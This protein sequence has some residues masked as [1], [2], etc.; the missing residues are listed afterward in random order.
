MTR[1]NFDWGLGAP[2][3]GH[4]PR[5]VLHPVDH[6]PHLHR[7]DLPVHRDRRRR[8]PG[9][10]RRR[11]RPSTGGRTRAPPP[12]GPPPPDRRRPHH[13]RRVLR[14]LAAPPSPNVTWTDITPPTTCS[15]VQWRVS[16]ST[17]LI[18][19]V[20]RWCAADDAIN[21]DWGLGAPMAGH[22]PRHGSPPG[23]PPPAPSPP[24]PT[25]SPRPPTTASGS[26]STA[27]PSSTGGRTRAPPPTGRTTDLT[28]GDAHH[29]RRVLRA[30]RRRRRPTSPG[31]T[32]PHPAC[33]AVQWSGRV[34]R[35]H[36]SVPVHR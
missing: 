27:P 33:S 12:T 7:R 10:G 22:R 31:P 8:H 28:A 18:C 26:R 3:A 16:T 29:H 19:P 20:H 1:S 4:R 34:L 17:P 11:H 21:F 25:G 23:G 14:E 5:H 36:G 6:H 32:S 24:G 2:M 30:R 35:R 13:H 15:A 9:Q